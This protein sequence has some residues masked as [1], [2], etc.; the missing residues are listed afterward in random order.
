MA[1][2]QGAAAVRISRTTR[3]ARSWTRAVPSS[4]PVT[5]TSPDGTLLATTAAGAIQ[6]WEVGT[7]REVLRFQGHPATP[8]RACFLP[9]GL[10]MSADFGGNFRV[11]NPKTGE[12]K[13]NFATAAHVYD[14]AV[15]PD[16]TRVLVA[17]DRPGPECLGVYDTRDG[18]KLH[19]LVGHQPVGSERL[20]VRVRGVA[21]SPN[22]DRVA[23]SGLDGVVRVWDVGTGK[24]V[25]TL[26]GHQGAV[27]R[28]RFSTDG[29]RVLSAG[30]DAVLK[31]WSLDAAAPLLELRPDPQPL[32]G[33]HVAADGSA[34]FT[35][36]L[37]GR[38]YRSDTSAVRATDRLELE[39]GRT[40]VRN[41][42]IR[43]AQGLVTVRGANQNPLAAWSLSTG[44]LTDWPS[45]GDPTQDG[46][47]AAAGKR[48][49]AGMVQPVYVLDAERQARAERHLAD[50]LAE[51]WR[52]GPPPVTQIPPAQP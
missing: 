29:A 1:A 16:G 46:P 38:L 15:S 34:V 17:G 23:S 13:Q 40:V 30:T 6:V 8:S 4:C 31:V 35:A 47:A 37:S 32:V 12:V 41:P 10:V 49:W 7:G 21:F 3:P 5:A 45:P 11:W 50:R 36:G 48:V 20:L 42:A 51:M 19:A 22:G 18:K 9:G 25:A 14:F 2:R 27:Y 52:A 26:R 33:L 43:P 28:V 24:N 44:R 39:D